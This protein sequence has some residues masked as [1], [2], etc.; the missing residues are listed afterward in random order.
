MQAQK[1][2]IAA[3]AALAASLALTSAAA[4]QD[5]SPPRARRHF[6][7]VSYDFMYNQ[8]LHFAEHPL[9][10]LVG[11]EVA[12]AEFQT[13][14][15]RTRDGEIL[16][17]VL[18]FERRTRGAGLTVYPIG[19]SEGP[20]LALRASYEELPIVRVAFD[21]DGAPPAYA[22]NGGRAY[23]L[24]IG[25]Y[26]ADRSPG[27]GLGSHAFVLGGFGRIRGDERDGNR[28]FAEG[29]GGLSTGPF[30]VELSIKFAWNRF[31]EPVEHQFMT[32]PI[33]VRGTLTF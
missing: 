16:I 29:G 11:R 6:V 10:D 7:T 8:P 31:T 18:E 22:F 9:E 28:Y 26:L 21:G 1:L 4:A 20:A 24:G 15:Y 5:Y 19:M 27:W 33:T 13:Y 17:D 23:D 14:D 12:S 32:V 3:A 2:T 30:G 25:V